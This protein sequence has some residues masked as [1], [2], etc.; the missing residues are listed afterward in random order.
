MKI[1]YLEK[2]MESNFK[3]FGDRVKTVTLFKCFRSGGLLYGYRDRYNI[4]SIA[5]E[6]I[7]SID[8]KTDFAL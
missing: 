3:R 7:Q 5:I 1:T 2:G 6:D 4:V 8:G